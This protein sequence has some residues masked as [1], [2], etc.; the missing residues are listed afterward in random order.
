MNPGQPLH[1]QCLT[2][3]SPSLPALW[4]QPSFVSPNKMACPP[5]HMGWEIHTLL[6]FPRIPK[7]LLSLLAPDPHSCFL[8][9]PGLAGC[10]TAWA[11][12]PPPFASAPSGCISASLLWFCRATLI[13]GYLGNQTFTEHWKWSQQAGTAHNLIHIRY[14]R[15]DF[16]LSSLQKNGI[17]FQA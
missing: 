12:W 13:R 2:H 9:I 4:A 8:W 11:C 10:L 3:L 1:I 14:Q 16:L 5:P 15:A 7:D 17:G 6:W